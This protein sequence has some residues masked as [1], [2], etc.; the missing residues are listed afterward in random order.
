[1]SVVTP[2]V[3]TKIVVTGVTVSLTE[4]EAVLLRNLLGGLKQKTRRG[5][6]R[7]NGGTR[8]QA[9]QANSMA[10]NLFK[11]LDEAGFKKYG[12]V[13]SSTFND[14]EVDSEEEGEDYD[15]YTDEEF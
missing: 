15:P 4:T 13:D 11:Q 10:S 9:E 2:A 1:M 5:A 7:K 12:A 8:E 3:E 14:E 6:V